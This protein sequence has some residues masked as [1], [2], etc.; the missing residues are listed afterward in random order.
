[1][2]G[3]GLTPIGDMAML[4][5]CSSHFSFEYQLIGLARMESE[6][7]DP[8]WKL[9]LRYGR[10]KTPF[11]HYTSIAEGVVGELA[12]GFVCP[13]GSAF[14]AMKTWASSDEESADM[15]QVIGKQI[16]FIVTGR[17]QVYETEPQQPPK[18][19]PYGYD[20]SFTPF[21]DSQ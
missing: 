15:I 13:S 18:D 1:M 9:K 3:A 14:M 8:N 21:D 2:T 19:N 4:R 7:P 6:Q 20:I 17:I 16:G 11:H 12:D 5:K 10:L